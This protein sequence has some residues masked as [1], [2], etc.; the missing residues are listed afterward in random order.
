MFGFGGL[1]INTAANYNIEAVTQATATS[2]E[3]DWKGTSGCALGMQCQ[4][5]DYRVFTTFS[6]FNGPY[7]I[8]LR[9]QYW[10]SIKSGACV[11]APES[12]GCQFGGVQTSYQLF[13]LTGNY[14]L[15][16][17]YTLRVGI[18]NL[19]DKKPPVSGGNPLGEPFPT[20]GT[21]SGSGGTYDP[22]GR[23]GFITF[24]MDF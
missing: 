15:S 20:L 11:T 6:Y 10:P 3:I 19:F 4:G 2:D 9:H 7:S 12:T 14:R 16:D 21:R 24:A 13:S 8:S 17:R 18:E 22:L 23:R 5:Y 1:N